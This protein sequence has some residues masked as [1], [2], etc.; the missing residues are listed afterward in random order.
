MVS[1]THFMVDALKLP[2][3]KLGNFISFQVLNIKVKLFYS[4]LS[5]M[6]KVHLLF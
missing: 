5:N 2:T 1:S 4:F 6:L 3:K